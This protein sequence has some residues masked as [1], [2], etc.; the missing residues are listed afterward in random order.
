MRIAVLVLACAC[1][2]CASDRDL[3]DQDQPPP[4]QQPA[5]SAPPSPKAA[6]TVVPT[7]ARNDPN[8]AN[9]RLMALSEKGRRNALFVIL[10]SSGESCKEVVR[11]FYQGS[12][13]PS[14]D[15]IW[16]VG[17]RGGPSYAILVRADAKG[18]TEIMTCESVRTVRAGTCFVR[19][20][21]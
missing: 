8:E 6:P 13:K 1:V 21:D 9:R 16:S 15:A 4:L 5:S 2:G 7:V 20:P 18:S 17:C 12:D 14:G 10:N 19:L 11:T 3:S